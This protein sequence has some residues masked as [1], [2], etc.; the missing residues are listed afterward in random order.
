M[1]AKAM[2]APFI[3]EGDVL[4]ESTDADA[5]NKTEES[6]SHSTLIALASQALHPFNVSL[7][8]LHPFDISLKYSINVCP[9]IFTNNKKLH[10]LE[11]QTV[12]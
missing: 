5:N 10:F 2:C 3:T 8:Y 9:N 7:K 4:L 6:Q 12:K 1:F 11:L